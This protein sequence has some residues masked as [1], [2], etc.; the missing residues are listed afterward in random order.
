LP[1]EISLVLKGT[2]NKFDREKNDIIYLT[3]E[4]ILDELLKNLEE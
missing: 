1:K 3:T 4:E 2:N